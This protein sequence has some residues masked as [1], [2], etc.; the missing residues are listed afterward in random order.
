MQARA[1]LNCPSFFALL[2]HHAAN[3]GSL[4]I[5][6]ANGA[7]NLVAGADDVE[8]VSLFLLNESN[9]G[10]AVGENGVVG[11]R[12]KTLGNGANAVDVLRGV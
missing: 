6:R 12:S 9:G 4:E 5:S 1:T 8:Q 2:L 3:A 11:R 10:F 7:E